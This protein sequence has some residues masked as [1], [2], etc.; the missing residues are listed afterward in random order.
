MKIDVT[1]GDVITPDK[2][3]YDYYLSF[4]IRTV[5]IYSYP[6]ETVFSE[7]LE[8]ILSRN[9]TNTRARD[10][11]DI[12]VLYNTRWEEVNVK[13][14]ND[15]LIATATNRESL[16]EVYD[17]KDIL[18]DISTSTTVISAWDRYQNENSYAQGIQFE[19]VFKII[20]S[21]LEV[22]DLSDKYI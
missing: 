2:I 17:Y 16:S 20:E 9:V 22:L 13:L 1:T 19:N 12:Y 7:K 21:I 3:E 18:K 15:A 8:T 4:E 6:L 10:F 5:P 11:Y 14:L